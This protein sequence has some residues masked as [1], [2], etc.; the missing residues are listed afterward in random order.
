MTLSTWLSFCV[1]AVLISVSPGPG[2]VFAMSTGMRRG[3][4]RTLPGIA[5]MQ[6]GVALQLLV[7]AIG[8]GAVLATSTHALT[9][10]KW[11]GAAYLIWLGW[12]QFF[13]RSQSNESSV[14]KDWGRDQ[15]H[16]A[17]AAK[18]F[19][20]GFLVNASNPKATVF[21]LAVLPQ[22]LDATQPLAQQYLAMAATLTVVDLFVM[23]G[24]AVLSSRMSRL[25]HKPAHVR[26]I[27]RL[28]GSLF[29][30]AGV[31]L[32]SWKRAA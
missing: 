32:A 7:V 21:F 23:S 11:I 27:D 31:V 20:Q 14:R 8:L 4:V 24:Y 6:L 2:A 3:Y 12:R 9:V 25:L 17:S 19:L 5:G 30:L 16:Q 26:W 22:F 13:A 29:M 15:G 28:F 10:I 1:A 18:V